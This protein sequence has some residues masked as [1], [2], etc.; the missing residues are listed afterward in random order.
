MDSILADSK[1]VISND[2]ELNIL[3]NIYASQ[4]HSKTITQRELAKVSGLS[5]GMTNALLKR[6]SD[7]GWLMLKKL[8]ARNIQYALT[9]EGVNEIAHR[10]YRYFKRTARAAGLYKDLVESWVIMKKREGAIRIVFAGVSDLDFLFEYA[11]ERHGLVF[12]KSVEHKKAFKLREDS[13]TVVVIADEPGPE[14]K[15]RELLGMNEKENLHFE[16][17]SDI[18]IGYKTNI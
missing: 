17:L 14:G 2:A 12:V 3:E 6:F 13:S 5:L 9:P 18:L 15:K 16:N 8:N 10:T 7:K 11:S 1:A 4:K